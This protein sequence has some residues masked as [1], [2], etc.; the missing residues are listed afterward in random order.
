[1][2]KSGAVA[3]QADTR[4]PSCGTTVPV[5]VGFVTWCHTCSW[6]VKASEPAYARLSRTERLYEAAG[7]RLGERMAARLIAAESLEPRMT[8][9]TFSAYAIAALAYAIVAAF[10]LAGVASIV[11]GFP[12]VF[13]LII[14]ALLVGMAVM[15]RP[16]FGKPPDE[17]LVWRAD[18]AALYEL[19]DE[20]ADALETP[21]VDMLVV[22]GEYNASW[23][24]LGLRRRRVLTLGLPLLTALGPQERVALLA[25]E[26][27]HGRNGD[28][29]RGFFVGS[30]VRALA[31]LYWIVAPEDMPEGPSW[32][33]GIFDR[34]A[35]WVFYVLSRPFWWLLMLELHL[36]LRDSQRAEYLADALAARVA[37]TEA[38]V[39][40]S[41]KWLLESTFRGVVQHAARAG[42][43]SDLFEELAAAVVEVPDRE[44]ERRRLVARLE[45]ARLDATHP[46]TAKRI[47]LLEKRPRQEPRV[48]LSPE[49]SAL[50]DA[51]LGSRRRAIQQDLVDEYRDSL[52]Q[53]DG[54]FVVT[55]ADDGY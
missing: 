33:L 39:A 2:G 24:I 9:A 37:G 32:A 11:L 16:R 6:N 25:H 19:A 45:G 48:S 28:A 17:D 46:P 7:R 50:I 35:N 47:E 21:R 27:A 18:G 53:S 15:L 51:E 23:A 4:C 55:G 13:A 30:A 10:L 49:R 42:D 5:H 44:R 38:A 40:L 43:D 34:A 3:G 29:R 41:E 52:Y 54:Y 22:D 12:N 36:L 31:D 8:P 20:V 1:M 14:G 26:L